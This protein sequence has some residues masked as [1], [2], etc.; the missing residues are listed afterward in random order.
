MDTNPLM[1]QENY[2]Q[3]YQDSVENLKNSPK[4][5]EF[6]RLC[7]EIFEHTDMGKAFIKTVRERYLEPAIAHK[8]APTYQ[9]DVLWQEGFKDFIRLILRSI[10]SHKH[11]IQAGI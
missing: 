10:D 4:L 6:D 11:R 8:G 1:M 9:I 2:W 3:G 7:Y 5:V